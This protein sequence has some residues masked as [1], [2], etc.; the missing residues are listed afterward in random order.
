MK[1]GLA[2][3]SSAHLIQVAGCHERLEL[4]RI[5]FLELIQGALQT[6]V[7]ADDEV[8]QHAL[9]VRVDDSAGL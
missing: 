1:I 5:A 4:G 6:L 2:K 9:L 3:C 8:P 7:A